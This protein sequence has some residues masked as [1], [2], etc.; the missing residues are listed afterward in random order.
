MNGSSYK[1]PCWT[2]SEKDVHPIV[3]TEA[4]AQNEEEKQRQGKEMEVERETESRRQKGREKNRPKTENP[5]GTA[6]KTEAG[7]GWGEGWEPQNSGRGSLGWDQT[8]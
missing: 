2:W 7:L 4:K 1:G 3:G 5:R 6:M 8:L